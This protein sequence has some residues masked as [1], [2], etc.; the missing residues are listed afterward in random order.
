[1]MKKM[2]SSTKEDAMKSILVISILAVLGV[3]VYIA[4]TIAGF[5]GY[6]LGEANLFVG[7]IGS[8][9]CIAG[10]GLVLYPES[11]TTGLG[12]ACIVL[13]GFLLIETMVSILA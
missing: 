2:K 7:A 3:V 9:L 8:V 4:I 1:M 13:G 11:R 12:I 5:V 6:P 10:G